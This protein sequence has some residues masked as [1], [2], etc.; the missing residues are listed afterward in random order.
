MTAR[1]L[2]AAAALAALLA[3]CVAAPPRPTYE[4]LLAAAP[5]SILIVPVL[6]DSVE[7]N[8]PE[9]F[10]STIPI[11]VAERGYYVFP[12]NLVK[13]ILEDDGLSDAGMVHA[14][15]PARLAALFGADAVLYVTIERWDAR[16]LVLSTTV[17]VQLTYV[18]KDGRTGD[19]LWRERRVA[20]Y[21]SDSG[22]GNSGVAGLIVAVVAAAVTKAAPDYLPLARVANE[23][24]MGSGGN[25]FPF[26]PHRP[27]Y[28]T[29]YQ[30]P[31]RPPPAPL[32]PPAPLEP[33]AGA[34]PVGP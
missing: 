1:H 30:R 17:T 16:Y 6:N 7:V 23:Q 24:A 14:A 11:P 31:G 26:G 4:K 3:G 13:R 29:D 33:G 27:E 10:L 5:R 19:T 12:V 21:Q 32:A 28:G 15:D 20:A 8:A 2:A 18:L 34:T 9:Y 25:G 22:G